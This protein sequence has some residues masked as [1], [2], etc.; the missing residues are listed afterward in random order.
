MYNDKKHK[1][2]ILLFLVIMSSGCERKIFVESQADNIPADYQTLDISSNPEGA[3]VYLNGKNTGFITPCKI[4]WI[5]NKPVS[6][7]LKLNPFSDYQFMI[8]KNQIT[9]NPVFYDFLLDD[10]NFGTAVCTTVPTGANII[11]NGKRQSDKTP[12][13][14]SL[15]R[16]EYTISDSNIRVIEAIVYMLP[17]LG[18]KVTLIL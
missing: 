16:P 12:H 3:D 5:E 7:T 8:Q 18:N 1:L 2:Y 11:I 15:L 6:V 4:K 14:Y 13:T 9:V 17:Y 10:R